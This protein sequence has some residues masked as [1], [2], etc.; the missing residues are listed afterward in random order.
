MPFCVP[1]FWGD[2]LT[3]CTSALGRSRFVDSCILDLAS[4]W[5]FDACKL[6]KHRR[7]LSHRQSREVLI[8]DH[9]PRHVGQRVATSKPPLFGFF[10]GVCLV[11]PFVVGRH[12]C[13]G[14]LKRYWQIRDTRTVLEPPPEAIDFCAPYVRRPAR[15]QRHFAPRRDRRR[16]FLP[17]SQTKAAHRMPRWRGFPF[18]RNVF[19]SSKAIRS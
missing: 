16:T 8:I 19:V 18:Q 7:R 4:V 14:H 9:T 1:T 3:F 12:V 5:S 10:S 11:P 15:G 17:I 6:T 13:S 2:R